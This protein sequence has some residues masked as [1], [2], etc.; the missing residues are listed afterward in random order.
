MRAAPGRSWAVA[1]MLY[2]DD[3]SASASSISY[4]CTRT[5]LSVSIP[6]PAMLSTAATTAFALAVDCVSF[7]LRAAWPRRADRRL[8]SESAVSIVRMGAAPEMPD[9][10]LTCCTWAFVGMRGSCGDIVDL[11]PQYS[12]AHPAADSV[13]VERSTGRRRMTNEASERRRGRESKAAPSGR[14]MGI[15]HRIQ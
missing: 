14:Y 3:L 12:I 4:T 7:C 5:S 15:G 9:V 13:D 11:R 1:V 6:S 2:C 10:Q 8:A